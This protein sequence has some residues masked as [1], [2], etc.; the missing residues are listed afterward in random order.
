M[1]TEYPNRCK[2][3]VHIHRFI[4]N[5]IGKNVTDEECQNLLTDAVQI[6]KEA[7]KNITV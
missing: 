4:Y 3:D 5:T 1:L 6:I 2:P 7:Y